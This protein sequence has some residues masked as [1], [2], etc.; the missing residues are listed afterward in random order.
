V[1]RRRWAAILLA[2]GL[3][4]GP[5][6]AEAKEPKLEVARAELGK[7]LTCHGEINPGREP[8]ILFLPGTGSD[9]SRVY[10]LGK[11]AFDALGRPVCV[12][13]FPHRTTADVQVSVQY[14][15]YAIRRTF[16]MA[17]RAVALAGV[18]QGGLLARIAL[19]YWPSVR[20][21]VSDVV[22]VAAP[23]H[24]STVGI[25]GLCD[26]RGC[27]PA[28]WQQAAGSR[29]LKALNSGR[30]ETPGPTSWTTVR[31][32]T[33]GLVQPQTGPAPTSA[34]RGARNVL[35]QRVCPGRVTSHLGAAVDSVTIA[36]LA[37]AIRYR[38]AAKPSRLPPDVCSHPYGTGLDE[39]Q[40]AFFL[41][42][43][44][45]LLGQSVA[46]VPRVR[47]EPRVRWWATRRALSPRLIRGHSRLELESQPNIRT[48][49]RQ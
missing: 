4:A 15:V 25:G 46:S 37:D 39:Q 27:P 43:G 26:E 42:L 38:G 6:A 48:G 7:A 35:I 21:R 31:S 11:G 49:G 41:E 5:V 19:T 28:V 16:R 14:L 10:A 29:F 32:A 36:V 47:H 8:P 20:T 45:Q 12:V 17:G 40:T 22:S 24:G 1:T 23:H 44:Q 33:D 3:A 30:D 34:L 9:G 2:A 13:A 18:S